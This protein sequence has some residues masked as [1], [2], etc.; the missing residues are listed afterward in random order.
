MDS[1]KGMKKEGQNA[2]VDKMVWQL[3]EL[4][5]LDIN[6]STLNLTKVSGVSVNDG[7]D[8][9]NDYNS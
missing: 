8:P 6:E 3:P 7:G 2:R 9:F 1:H 4:I 5:E